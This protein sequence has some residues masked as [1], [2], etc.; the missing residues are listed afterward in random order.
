MQINANTT[1]MPAGL[2]LAT[3]KDGRDHC[4]VVV[5]G[6]FEVGDDGEPRP[7]E[8]QEPLV[9][10]D[11]HHGDPGATSLN[12]E[13]EFALFKPRA[14]VIVNGQAVAPQGKPVRELTVVLE[15]GG[16][17]KEVR[18]VGDRRWKAGILGFSATEPE[19][20]VTMPLVY[21][22][23]FGGSDLSHPDPKYHGTEVRNTVGVGFHKNSDAATI[24]GQPLPNLEQPRKPMQM[25][26]DTPP[27]IGFGAVGRN[28]QPRLKFAGTYD[29]RWRDERFPFL[30][31]DFDPQYFQSAPADQQV[32]H[33]EGG[34]VIRCIH[35]TPNGVFEVRVPR[36][37]VPLVYRFRDRDV[38]ATPKL[39][40]LI[41]EPSLRRV[42]A[43]WRGSVPLGRKLHALREVVVGPQLTPAVV[44]GTNGKRRFGSL[45][46][47]AAWNRAHGV[48]RSRKPQM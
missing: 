1:G 28:W 47:L 25:W 4:V 48:R 27:P 42:L 39:D 40:T 26:S 7:A 6:T 3:D 35:M 14:D 22:R 2:A 21:E 32:P 43:V 41:V 15:A 44:A 12:Y 30:P 36:F 9:F 37:D 45:A 20:F 13:C 10:T 33:F 11:I 24:E 23:A 16:S 31:A 29:Q 19:P 5:K 34:E 8:E 18:V 46:E 17:R 38:R